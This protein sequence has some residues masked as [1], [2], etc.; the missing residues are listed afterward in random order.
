MRKSR[1]FEALKLL[2]CILLSMAAGLIGMIFT[3]TGPDSWYAQLIKPSF[4]PPGWIFG[5]VWT[6]LY[7]LMGIA[8][9]LVLKYKDNR[10]A[11]ILFISQLILNTLWTIIFFGMHNPLL[12]FI[13]IIILWVLILLTIIEFYK[14]SKIA[15]YL[16]IPYILWVSFASILTLAIHL[17]N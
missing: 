3:K 15:A 13:E 6:T 16:L 2:G 4:N 17:L 5:P 10:K 14:K 1:A 11:K 7:I 9:Y 12:A 8:F